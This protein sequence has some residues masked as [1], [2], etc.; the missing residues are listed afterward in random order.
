[1]LEIEPIAAFRDNYIWALSVSAVAVVVDPGDA[2]PVERW[3]VQHGRRLA[4]ILVTHHHHDHIGGLAALKRRWAPRVYGPAAEP[5]EEVDL[6]VAEGDRI[7]PAAGFPAFGVLEVPGHTG[8]HVAYYGAGLLFCGDTMFSAGC[9]RLFEGTP[10]QMYRSLSRLA[11]LPAETRV[12]AAH[13]YTVDNLR[14]ARSL[15]PADGALAQALENAV[16]IRADAQATLPS[17]IGREREINLFLRVGEPELR[18]AIAERTG[19]SLPT[20]SEVFAALRR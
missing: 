2:A 11:A 19:G 18:A 1:M 17:T 13:E 12:Y 14:F 3:L 16:T 9:G 20:H 7:S 10:A 5:I 15:L 4:A 6:A 8:G